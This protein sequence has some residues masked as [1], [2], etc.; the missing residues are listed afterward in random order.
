MPPN[1]KSLAA[2]IREK[3]KRGFQE[4]K[5]AVNEAADPSYLGP[6]LPYLANEVLSVATT[7]Q[8]QPN[9]ERLQNVQ[10][11]HSSGTSD[12]IIMDDGLDLDPDLEVRELTY[13]LFMY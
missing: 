10:A 3:H 5:E 12:D 13:L 6:V 8:L 7:T 1:A 4:P 2:R 11:V 9:S